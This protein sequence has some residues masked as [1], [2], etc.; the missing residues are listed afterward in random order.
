MN[1]IDIYEVWNTEDERQACSD[2]LHAA[3]IDNIKC[4]HIVCIKNPKNP[5]DSWD[6]R[7]A[8]KITDIFLNKIFKANGD[9]LLDPTNVCYAELSQSDLSDESKMR[10]ILKKQLEF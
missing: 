7:Y 10:G 5:A 1:E 2:I 9:F 6:K 8:K 4:L 3:C